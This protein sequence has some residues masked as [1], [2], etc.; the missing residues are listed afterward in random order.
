MATI[1]NII[2][3]LKSKISELVV[4]N[5][6]L[7]AELEEIKEKEAQQAEVSTTQDSE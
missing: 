6:I 2:N 7:S 5:A 4:E 3:N 1:E